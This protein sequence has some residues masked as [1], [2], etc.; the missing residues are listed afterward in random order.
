MGVEHWSVE[1]IPREVKACPEGHRLQMY[2]GRELDCCTCYVLYKNKTQQS[3]CVTTMQLQLG[4]KIEVATKGVAS[5]V[6][7]RAEAYVDFGWSTE[8]G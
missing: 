1:A 4:K 5:M 2:G 8:K 7:L 6:T 3:M